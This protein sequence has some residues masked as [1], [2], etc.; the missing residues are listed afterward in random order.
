MVDGGQCSLHPNVP[1]VLYGGEPWCRFCEASKHRVVEQLRRWLLVSQWGLVV[2]VPL[3]LAG[4]CALAP[5]GS[6]P[7]TDLRG[8]WG[9]MLGD[10]PLALGVL[11]LEIDKLPREFWW[12]LLFPSAFVSCG[13]AAVAGRLTIG[14]VARLSAWFHPTHALRDWALIALFFALLYALALGLEQNLLR[15]T[16]AANEVS[17]WLTVRA[18]LILVFGSL[19]VWLLDRWKLITPHALLP[20][21]GRRSRW[22]ATYGIWLVLLYLPVQWVLAGIAVSGAGMPLLLLSLGAALF[23]GLLYPPVTRKLLQTADSLGPSREGPVPATIALVGPSNVGKTVFLTRA[24]SLLAQAVYGEAISLEPTRESSEILGPLIHTLEVEREWPPGTVKVAE[25]PFSLFYRLKEI[26]RFK[27]IDLP[28]GVFTN[29]GQWLE[30]AEAFERQLVN[31]DAVA[32]LLDA[33]DLEEAL[34][35]PNVPYRATYHGVARE[36]YG[37]LQEVGEAARPIPLAIIVT[38][39]CRAKAAARQLRS[40][41]P[42]RQLAGDWQT[43]AAA[44][45]LQRPAVR[46]FVSTAVVNSPNEPNQVPTGNHPIL[47]EQTVEPVFWLAAQTMRANMGL[48]DLAAG[49]GGRSELQEAIQRL[50]RLA[51]G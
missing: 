11:R 21:T 4:L 6:R 45:H 17:R 46:I 22:A 35:K 28:G 41:L 7:V 29:R 31:C 23:F 24:Y 32:M 15:L 43:A 37:R 18:P 51:E 48:L 47:S 34:D 13:L 36:L 42:L 16:P 30:E 44:A 19:A 20:L 14:R 2:A 5:P 1:L 49:F 9:F 25:I 8:F 39:S 3:S 12:W 27:W 10:M 50:E 40:A 33:L 26:L 38:K